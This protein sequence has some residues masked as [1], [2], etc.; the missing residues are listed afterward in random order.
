MAGCLL[1]A[2]NLQ[3]AES[4]PEA[5]PAE[6]SMA[7]IQNG[8]TVE[9]DYT[10]TVDGKV[11]D[12]SN[13][14]SPLSYVHGQHQLIPGLERP[15]AGMHVG[16]SKDVTVS[17]EDGYGPVDPAA[18]IEVPKEQLPKNI[19]L[20]V[21]LMLRGTNPNGQPFRATVSKIGEKTVTLD[22]NHPL[23]GKALQF[24]VKVTKVTAGG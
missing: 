4:T 11:V 20:E 22:L 17:V 7:A 2:T 21:G 15:L 1:C 8:A 6:A 9:L 12:S 24:N 13:R 23:A 18:F 16:D 3:A 14:R 10:L 5:R 19:T